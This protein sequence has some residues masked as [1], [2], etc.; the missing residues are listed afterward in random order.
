M[1]DE[2][3]KTQSVILNI[4]LSVLKVIESYT[5]IRKINSIE[6]AIIDLIKGNDLYM[7]RETHMEE[8]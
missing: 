6:E 8:E 7:I 5:K 2:S 3:E 1:E 4:P